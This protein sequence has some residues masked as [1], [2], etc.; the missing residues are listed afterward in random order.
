VTGDM[1]RIPM[2]DLREAEPLNAFYF[3]P[4]IRPGQSLATIF[5]TH[6]SLERRLKELDKI[7]KQLGQ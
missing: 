4:A 6:P 3:A 7:S 2:K 1:G 5:S